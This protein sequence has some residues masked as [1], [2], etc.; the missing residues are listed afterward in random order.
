MTKSNPKTG[1]TGW[2][3]GGD[4]PEPQIWEDPKPL[5]KEEAARLVPSDSHTGTDPLGRAI[6]PAEDHTKAKKVLNDK[7]EIV[8]PKIPTKPRRS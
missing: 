2:M 1:P 3:L 4:P 8:T 5:T 6:G 7:G